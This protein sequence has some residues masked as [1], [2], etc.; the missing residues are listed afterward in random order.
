LPDAANQALIAV[1]LAFINSKAAKK[2]LIKVRIFLV[3][4]MALRLLAFAIV[5]KSSFQ[6]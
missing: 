5:P 1:G 2:R 6:E 3:L 4:K